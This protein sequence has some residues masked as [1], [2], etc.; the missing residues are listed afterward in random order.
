VSVAVA[1]AVMVEAEAASAVRVE[2]LGQEEASPEENI[3]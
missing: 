3:S 2:E 1:P